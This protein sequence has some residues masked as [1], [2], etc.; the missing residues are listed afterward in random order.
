[1]SRR[2]LL[3]AGGSGSFAG[4]ALNDTVLAVTSP[5]D[6]GWPGQTGILSIGGV[7]SFGYIDGSGNVEH[8]AL[9]ES[10]GDVSAAVTTRASLEV[11]H[12]NSPALVRL[13]DGRW[14]TAY[15]RHAGSEMYVRISTNTPAEVGS[16]TWDTETNIDATLGGSLYT[17]PNLFQRTD[18]TVFLWYRDTEFAGG[19]TSIWAY[20]T[21]TSGGGWTAQTQVWR[22]AQTLSYGHVEFDGD[23]R[24]DI[25]IS[26]A[27][28]GS[29]S[30]Y[31]FYRDGAT[32]HKSDGTVIDAGDLPFGTA[33][34][35]LAYSGAAGGVRVPFDLHYNGGLIRALVSCVGATNYDYKEL[36]WSGSAWSTVAVLTNTGAAAAFVEGGL[37]Y[38][39]TDPTIAYLS[40]YSGAQWHIYRYRFNGS[41]WVQS[42]QI[43]TTGGPHFYPVRVRDRGSVP[44]AWLEG[45]FIA[46]GDFNLGVNA[47]S[48]SGVT[49]P[50]EPPPDDPPPVDPGYGAGDATAGVSGTCTTTVANGGDIQAAIDAASNG[51]VVCLTAGGDYELT[52]T[53]HID[54]FAGITLDGKG[55]TVHMDSVSSPFAEMI[56]VSSCTDAELRNMVIRGSHANPGTYTPG[57]T[58]F[59]A[60]IAFVNS[61]GLVEYCDIRNNYGDAVGIYG[62]SSD[63][64]VR[65]VTAIGNGRTGF[66]A[67]HAERILYSRCL[68]ENNG[69]AYWDFEPDGGG[70]FVDDVTIEDCEL[71]GIGKHMVG[72]YGPGVVSNVIARRVHVAAGP[73]RGIWSNIEQTGGFRA[74]NITFED[75]VG[76]QQFWDDPGW[77]G[78]F[79][80]HAVDGLTIRRCS[81]PVTPGFGMYAVYRQD[82]P[83]GIVLEDNDFPGIVAELGP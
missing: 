6:G 47:L 16:V 62:A 9:T 77:R 34:A 5:N 53:L 55:A 71:G 59:Q 42:D 3:V 21:W 79:L 45:T 58:E 69:F 43:T 24:F 73:N 81:Q 37:C 14:M 1:V 54:S 40:R 44:V 52:D 4:P 17:Y 39:D 36:R 29:A 7:T 22:V 60:G 19:E 2:L 30:A 12:H 48:T 31:H 51:D 50:E 32:W 64:T 75:C 25:L 68:M 67:T 49:P 63:V 83:T 15:C 65:R 56:Y 33:D 61:T 8:R 72:V 27:T 28:G 78:I 11:D 70:D 10:M 46:Q 57:V 66:A 35:T 41:A 13:A 20:A 38:D 26:D 82:S 74:V 18:G 23:D 80:A 76:D